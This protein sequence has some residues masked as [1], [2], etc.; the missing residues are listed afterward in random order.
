MSET[1]AVG[2]APDK[3][4]LT[5][6][7]PLEVGPGRWRVE[8]FGEIDMSN[9]SSLTTACAALVDGSRVTLEI[10]LEGLTY[11]D[12]SGIG[13]MVVILRELESRGGSLHV[14]HPSGIVRRVLEISGL[15]E[16][17]A[18]PAS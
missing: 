11:L 16:L 9:A 3:P 15:L 8:L 10:D 12:S 2:A 5:L 17:L 4:I 18:D 13:A 6:D 14:L 7:G 1:Q